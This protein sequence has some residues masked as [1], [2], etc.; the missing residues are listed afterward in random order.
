MT[1]A[2][3]QDVE[4]GVFL[5]VDQF[6]HQ[7]ENSG[8]LTLATVR[9]LEI[10]GDAIRLSPVVPRVFFG[11]H[12]LVCLLSIYRSFSYSYLSEPARPGAIIAPEPGFR[13]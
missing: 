13:S 9:R 4:P 10:F 7:R 1:T 6:N 3:I 11:F 5:R 8:A 12:D 2:N